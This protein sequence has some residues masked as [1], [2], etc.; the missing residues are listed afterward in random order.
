MARKNR[1]DMLEL[2]VDG[3]PVSKRISEWIAEKPRLL[4]KVLYAHDK[5]F[6]LSLTHDTHELL[7]NRI[8]EQN[9][10]IESTFKH[11]KNKKI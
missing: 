3:E 7:K 4:W 8:E 9:R 11:G 1:Y 10:K 6:K 2:I 5:P